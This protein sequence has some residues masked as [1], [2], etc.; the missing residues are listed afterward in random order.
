MDNPIFEDLL[1][2]VQSKTYRPILERI[3]AYEDKVMHEGG[4][5][6]KDE[7]PVRPLGW[8]WFEVQVAPGYLV[9][10]AHAGTIGIVHR[11]NKHTV[12]RLA[13]PDAVRRALA[14]E[15]AEPTRALF[16]V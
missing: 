6:R 4:W 14:G 13:D 5:H 15:I 12:Y 16:S 1:R 11:S 9:Q 3:L 10:L 8:E 7:N 2:F